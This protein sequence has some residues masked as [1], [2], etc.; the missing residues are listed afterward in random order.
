MVMKQISQVTVKPKEIGLWG[1]SSDTVVQGCTFSGFEI[2][3]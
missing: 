2:K 1:E 3:G